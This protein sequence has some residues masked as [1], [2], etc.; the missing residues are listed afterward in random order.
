MNVQNAIP[1]PR[2]MGVIREFGGKMHMTESM[3]RNQQ[4]A[5]K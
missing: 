1:H 2:T 5:C 4:E 3:Y